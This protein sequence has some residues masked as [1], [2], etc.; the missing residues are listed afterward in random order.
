MRH[1]RRLSHTA[2]VRLLVRGSTLDDLFVAALDAL[3]DL[4]QH[5]FCQSAPRLVRRTTIL[6]EA[7]DRTTLLIDFLSAVL[8]RT[9]LERVVFCQV[10]FREL[11]DRRLTAEL[12]GAPLDRF[13]HDVKAVTYHEA[14][15]RQ[16]A[17]GA[18]ETL[19]VV[20]V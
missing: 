15:I 13:D 17:D 8:T 20:D 7:T 1:F 11:N 18:Y 2:D 14:A 3:N 6:A 10:H 4:L 16:A 12:R 19:V 5:G 9:M